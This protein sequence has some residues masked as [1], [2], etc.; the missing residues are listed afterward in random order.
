MLVQNR[1]SP[2]GTGKAGQ[3]APEQRH[4]RP[5]GL[6]RRARTGRRHVFRTMIAPAAWSNQASGT[7]VRR[8]SGGFMLAGWAGL[9][10]RM[11]PEQADRVAPKAVTPCDDREWFEWGCSWGATLFKG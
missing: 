1:Q 7:T 8:L 9:A 5:S 2:T 6:F 11:P 10:A 4:W 3:A